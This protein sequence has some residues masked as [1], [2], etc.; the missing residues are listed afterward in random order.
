MGVIVTSLGTPRSAGENLGCTWDHLGAPVTSLRALAARLGAPTTS[1]G[2]PA[3]TLGA[4]RITV[5]QSGRIFIFGN[6]GHCPRNH[7]YYLLF[8]DF[9][10]SCLQCVLSSMYLSS[11]PSTHGK[12]GLAA[13]GT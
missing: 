11:Y 4:P 2:A 12:S 8:N 6:A 9:Q 7:S 10:N 3:S 5:W 1:L 13:G